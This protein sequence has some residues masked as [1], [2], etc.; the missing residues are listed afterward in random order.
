MGKIFQEFIDYSIKRKCSI[1]FSD[2]YIDINDLYTETAKG[3]C[4]IVPQNNMY[5]VT[6]YIVENMHSFLHM[7]S[8]IFMFDYDCTETPF[9]QQ[10][11]NVECRIC[12][13]FLGW[14]FDTF[15]ILL[16]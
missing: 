13:T 14:K 10:T 1:C 8:S 7:N 9:T 11:Q 16:T 5:N 6:S 4:K 2:L 3:K 12:S 15:Y